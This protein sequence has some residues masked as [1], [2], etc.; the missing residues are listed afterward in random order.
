MALP[1]SFRWHKDF[2]ER[3]DLARG[4]VSRS[5]FVRDAVEKKIE[6]DEPPLVRPAEPVEVPAEGGV[7][8]LIRYGCRYCD[9][10]AP[11]P[12]ARCLHHSGQ[13]VAL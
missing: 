7:R 1:V 2:I 12:V 5:A 6:A 4:S 3:I 8:P 13:L 10:T 9:F 11:S